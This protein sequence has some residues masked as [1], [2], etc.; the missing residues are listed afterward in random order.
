L[1]QCN[2]IGVDGA[3]LFGLSTGLASWHLTFAEAALAEPK[4]KG[5]TGL[6]STVVAFAD[7]RTE[8]EVEFAKVGTGDDTCSDMC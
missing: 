3:V 2:I 1:R 4:A 7:Q 5:S 8:I 6:G